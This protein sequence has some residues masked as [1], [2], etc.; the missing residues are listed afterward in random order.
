MLYLCFC[1]HASFFPHFHEVI[2]NYNFFCQSVEACG[3]LLKPGIQRYARRILQ[4]LSDVS[5]DP[6]LAEAPRTPDRIKDAGSFG[7]FLDDQLSEVWHVL[8]FF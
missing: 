2:N 3:G 6:I 5:S 1:S 4:Y 8:C 7:V